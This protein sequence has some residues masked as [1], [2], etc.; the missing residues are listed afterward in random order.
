M[1]ANYHCNHANSGSSTAC[2][3]T[4]HCLVV[5]D[6]GYKTNGGFTVILLKMN[7]GLIQFGKT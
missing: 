2:V 7:H 4:P 1:Y 5:G 6:T 3:L